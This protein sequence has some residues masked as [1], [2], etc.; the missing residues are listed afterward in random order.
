MTSTSHGTG[1]PRSCSILLPRNYGVREVA[2]ASGSKDKVSIRLMDQG[3]HLDNVG[4]R[5]VHPC[6]ARE[7]MVPYLDFLPI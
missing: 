1:Q 3:G 5:I 6:L 7:T 4:P 2:I